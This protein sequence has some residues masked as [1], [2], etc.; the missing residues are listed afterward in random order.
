MSTVSRFIGVWISADG[1]SG[2][3]GVH[4]ERFL[5]NGPECQFQVRHQLVVAKVHSWGVQLAGELDPAAEAE[6]L[7]QW[8]ASYRASGGIGG[9]LPPRRETG[10]RWQAVIRAV[11]RDETS[12]RGAACSRRG[13]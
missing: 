1:W 7:A 11:V 13:R 9:W 6:R 12:L 3:C 2:L 4:Q 10:E 8:A 5:P